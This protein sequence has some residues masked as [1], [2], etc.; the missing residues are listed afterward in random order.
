MLIEIH[1]VELSGLIVNADRYSTSFQEARNPTS[2]YQDSSKRAIVFDSWLTSMTIAF[3]IVGRAPI[4]TAQKLVQARAYAHGL[5][6]A[7]LNISAA[8][9]VN[10]AKKGSSRF[11]TVK[12]LGPSDP[13][14]KRLIEKKVRREE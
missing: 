12:V 6:L 9:E 1:C 14:H 8:F 4:S 10:V 5:T 7:V 11:Q 3:T 13:E 2:F